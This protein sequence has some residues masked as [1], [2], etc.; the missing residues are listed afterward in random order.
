VP[1]VAP[2]PRG[3][4][5]RAAGGGVDGGNNGSGTGAG[6]RAFR[7]W[8][9]GR[10]QPPPP[11]IPL[12]LLFRFLLL[13]PASAGGSGGGDPPYF[14]SSRP[15]LEEMQIRLVSRKIE[16][17]SH[18]S[19]LPEYTP[20]IPE[21]KM[22]QDS[23]SILILKHGFCMFGCGFDSARHHFLL[24]YSQFHIHISSLPSTHPTS[25]R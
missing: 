18:V 14:R 7:R 24:P 15:T 21:M 16:P 25:R 8:P 10:N 2:H 12:H 17:T 11:P 23:R 4:R 9:Q 19:R 6:S 20:Q 5:P 13:H 22:A 3:P 1:A